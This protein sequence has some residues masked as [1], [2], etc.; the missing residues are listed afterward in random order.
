M[1]I[2][3]ISGWVK[4]GKDTAAGLLIK[5]LGFSRVAYADPLKENVARDF[6]V[7]LSDLHSQEGKEAPLL[8]MPVFCKDGFS[9]N[10]NKFMF[11]EFRTAEGK[12]PT[13]QQT[14][15]VNE[16]GQMFAVD[17]NMI[18]SNPVPLYWNRRALCIAEGSTKRCVDPDYWVTKAIK[19]AKE[20][21]KELLVIS[22]LRYRNELSATSKAINPETDKFI[23]IRINRFD[24]TESNDPS[25]NDL[26]DATFDHIVENRGTL[27]EFLNKIKTITKNQIK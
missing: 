12:R 18:F 4:S 14:Y 13:P 7:K 5:E 26:N 25:E 10:F 22:D 15:N 19:S 16:T 8:D 11:S 27:E 2:I 9:F 6:D 3:G 20:S 24:T 17:N 23:T 1:V 21:G